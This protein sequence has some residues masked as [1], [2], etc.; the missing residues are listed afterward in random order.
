VTLGARMSLEDRRRFVG[1]TA[2]LTAIDELFVDE[3]PA[4]VVLLHGPGGIGKSALLREVARRGTSAGWSPFLVEGRDLPPVPDAVD[5][6]LASARRLNRPLVLVDSYEHMAALGHHLR[7]VVLPELPDDAIVVIAG[8]Q[9][10]DPGWL[11]GG[12]EAV[13]REIELSP[14]SSDESLA[15]LASHGLEDRSR[16]PQL[17]AWAAGSPLALTLLARAGGH[18]AWQP[19]EDEPRELVRTLVARLVDDELDLPRRDVLWVACIAR[20]TTAGL[21]RDVLA[22]VDAS[23]A[24]RWLARRSFTEPLADGIT[25]HDLV[26]R[27]LRADLHQRDPERERDLRRRIVDSVHA[28]AVAGRPLLTIDLA[29]LLETPEFRALYGW[30]GAVRN[31]LD[32][33]RAGDAEQVAD[34]LAAIDGSEW[35]EPTSVLF[36]HAPSI[37]TIA[38]DTTGALCGYGIAVTPASA[39]PVARA[40]PVLGPWLAHARDLAPDGNV[41]LCRDLIDFTRDPTSRIQ[42]M[43]NV[44]AVLRSGLANPRYVYLPIDPQRDDLVTFSALLGARHVPELDLDVERVQCHLLDCG[45]GG[46]LG[47]QRDVLYL[48][49]GLPAPGTPEPPTPTPS[50]PGA[51]DPTTVRDA[52]RNLRVPVVL[53]DSPLAR[54]H[55]VDERAG[56]VRRLLEQAA[57]HAFGDSADEHLL[58]QVLVRGYLDPGASHEHT[59]R[60][61]NLSR[62]AYF[63]RLRRASERVAE[64]LAGGGLRA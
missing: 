55:G 27:A 57:A 19:G 1:R 17:A 38:R 35:W 18:P 59:A 33:V 11:Q 23:G 49:L 60:E 9:P 8:R 3:P 32:R 36:E 29:E 2:E 61:L 10:P 31:R 52:L 63:R 16:A 43:L 56:S 28:A 44:S 40:D 21:I 6:A 5:E 54:G 7:R 30:E 42:A 34:N 15:L 41:L 64:Y 13:T 25:L 46:A 4:S 62:A 48:E 37:V 12:W 20:V 24:M 53:A 47:L 39:P 50:P 22:D 51:V 14:L 26:R 45:P 58:H